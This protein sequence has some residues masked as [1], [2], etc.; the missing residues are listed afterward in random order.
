M[1]GRGCGAGSGGDGDGEFLTGLAVGA[2][3]ADVVVVPGS[4]EGDVGG[5]GGDGVSDGV[6]AGAGV[7][8]SFGYLY[9]VVC[10]G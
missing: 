6:V 7:E 3:C 9:H 4:G 8:G 2:E 10:V 5:A 1:G